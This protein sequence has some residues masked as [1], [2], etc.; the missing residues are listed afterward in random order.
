[1]E[2][3]WKHLLP[4][5]TDKV[6]SE[7]KNTVKLQEKLA[8]LHVLLPSG[9]SQ[10]E[11]A[12]EIEGKKFTLDKDTS[13]FDHISFHF[14]EDSIRMSVSKSSQKE[15]WNIGIGYWIKNDIMRKS[16]R[17]IVFMTGI[18][19]DKSTLLFQSRFV[20]TPYAVYY[21][22]TFLHGKIFE[23]SKI[24]LYFDDTWWDQD[25]CWQENIIF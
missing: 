13:E 11:Q 4:G 1:M 18:W 15:V 8:R 19:Q 5:V 10:S 9:S 12:V 23:E 6:L 25:L 17:N 22:F 2:A 3:I 24:N 20:E 21:R 14:G 7:D 16:R